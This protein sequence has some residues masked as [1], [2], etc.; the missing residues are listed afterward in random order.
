MKRIKIKELLSNHQIGETVCV[1][2]WVRTKRESKGVAFVALNDGSAINSI[3]IVVDSPQFEE[4][5]LKR[6]TTGSCV[7]V[8]GEVVAS[9]GKG[10][11][12][13]LTAKK[14]E[15][16]GDADPE[17][18]PLQPKEHSL[19]FLREIAH[20]RMRTNTFG[21]IFRIRHAMAF[22]VHKFFN[23][24]GFVYLH[25]P[26]ITGAD[27]EGAGQMFKVTTFD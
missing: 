26:I 1:K 4:S 19:E 8:I 13:E 2:G 15:I 3:Q 6:V 18:Y 5:L 9:Q 10:Q 14:I 21:A 7:S 27:C 24:R 16:L 20:L 23:E 22:A 25:T 17:K 11:A 12:I